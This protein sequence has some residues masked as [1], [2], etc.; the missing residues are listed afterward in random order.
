MFV[1]RYVRLRPSFNIDHYN[2]GRVDQFKYLEMI[3]T[4][5]NVMAKDI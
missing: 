5:N 2:F 3:L 4:Q 1:S